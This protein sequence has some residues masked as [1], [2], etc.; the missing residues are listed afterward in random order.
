MTGERDGTDSAAFE[1]ILNAIRT[2]TKS[3]CRKKNL[4]DAARTGGSTEEMDDHPDSG[5]SRFL[6]FCIP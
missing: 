3:A 4:I 1:P 6:P 5:N 2:D